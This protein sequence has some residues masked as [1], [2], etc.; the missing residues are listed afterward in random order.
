MLYRT[1]VSSLPLFVFIS[2]THAFRNR[3]GCY[4]KD[5]KRRLSCLPIADFGSPVMLIS[6]HGQFFNFS[7]ASSKLCHQEVYVCSYG[8]PSGNYLHI[9][10]YLYILVAAMAIIANK[11]IFRN[12][13]FVCYLTHI[14]LKNFICNKVIQIILSHLNTIRNIVRIQKYFRGGGGPRDIFKLIRIRGSLMC[15]NICAPNVL[16]L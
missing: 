6:E 5:D 15:S 14:F 13:D 4:Y 12:S 7:K 2:G 8:T 9:Y 3:H 16:T 10:I 1:G 11:P